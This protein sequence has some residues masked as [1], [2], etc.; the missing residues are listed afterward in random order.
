MKTKRAITGFLFLFLFAPALMT[1][2]WA[3]QPETIK[4]WP[5][6]VPNAR[7]GM[8]AEGTTVTAAGQNGASEAVTNVSDPAL[9]VYLPPADKATGAAM[10]ICPGGGYKCLV[11]TKEGAEI[12]QWLNGFG[13][14]GL[15]LKYRV[16]DNREGACQDVQRAIRLVRSHSVAWGID[17]KRV[18]VMGFSAGGNLAAWASNNFQKPIYKAVDEAD[19]QPMR[20]D[21]A[22][23]VYPGW[24]V[25]PG[26]TKLSPDMPV[27]ARTTPTFI[28]QA[29][30]DHY[31]IEG[32]IY[33]FAELKKASVPRCEMH[34]YS[35]GGHGFALR[36]VKTNASVEGWPELCR[37]WMSD[38]GAFKNV[39]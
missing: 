36:P 32:N 19:R 33:Y 3:A 21:F 18:G 26:E 17:P 34:M 27:T 10:I 7:P 16:P 20:P 8:A 12:A 31:G 23:L 5:A 4:L 9:M 22:I 24:L 25:F 38:I 11:M 2:V 1:R 13:V 29:Y 15:V 6:G 35:A 30:D 28:V 14:A 37:K 39:N